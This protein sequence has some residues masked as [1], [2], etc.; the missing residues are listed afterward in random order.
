MLTIY[1][2]VAAF[3]SR[4]LLLLQVV[5]EIENDDKP[6]F[7]DDEYKALLPRPTCNVSYSYAV[8]QQTVTLTITR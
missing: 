3:V 6:S 5:I 1:S 2:D 7:D 4:V 8:L